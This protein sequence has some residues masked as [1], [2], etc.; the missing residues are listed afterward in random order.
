MC[1]LL[2]WGWGGGALVMVVVA[3][4]DHQGWSVHHCGPMEFMK[5]CGNWPEPRNG[6]MTMGLRHPLWHPN[7][8]N[9]KVNGPL[10]APMTS[11]KATLL[12]KDLQKMLLKILNVYAFVNPHVAPP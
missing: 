3:L 6:G 12:H 8:Q 11:C 4:M 9:G 10:L 7:C 5:K 2:G 1:P